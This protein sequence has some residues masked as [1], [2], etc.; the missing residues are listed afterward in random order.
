MQQPIV[1]VQ[2]SVL[3]P[4]AEV[5]DAIIDP[6]KL[7]AYFTETASD[8]MLAGKE[9]I[10]KFPEFP[11]Q[12]PVTILEVISNQLIKLEWTQEGGYKTQ[13]EIHLK[14]IENDH[15][16]ALTIIES[17]WSSDETAIK[18]SYQN[19]GGWM[20]MLC[21]LKAYLEYGINL[22]KGSFLAFDFN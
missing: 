22:R 18:N 2:L 11:D 6:H 13:V 19:C 5:F 16:T 8:K 15:A 14:A 12:I 1:K 7:S 10:W 21:S 9:V 3:K 20:H 4:V 17:G